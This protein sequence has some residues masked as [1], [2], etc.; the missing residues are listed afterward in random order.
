MKFNKLGIV[1]KVAICWSIITV[2]GIYAFYLSKRSI[3][4]NRYEHMKIR[5][6]MYASYT[7]NTVADQISNE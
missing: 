2:G 4:A 1:S 3:V 7:S 6:R 5:E